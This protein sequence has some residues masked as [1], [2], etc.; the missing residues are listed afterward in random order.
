VEQ[1]AAEANPLPNVVPSPIPQELLD[2]VA[3]HNVTAI[4]AGN[5]DYAQINLPESA[6]NWQEHFNNEIERISS[7]GEQLD[8]R[9]TG[10]MQDILQTHAQANAEEVE[11]TPEVT[12]LVHPDMTL[13]HEAEL[14]TS[15]AMASV[16]L[17]E[18]AADIITEI[19][20]NHSQTETAALVDE[21][22]NN[23]QP[24]NLAE[25][26]ALP[27]TVTGLPFEAAYNRAVQENRLTP[28]L[29]ERY[30]SAV[31]TYNAFASLDKT[32]Q[33][34]RG[35]K[36]KTDT[37]QSVTEVVN[38]FGSPSA[39]RALASGLVNADNVNAGIGGQDET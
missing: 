5:S 31:K 39:Q 38:E 33:V 26:Q 6:D 35:I 11:P 15:V 20:S 19:G 25:V 27:Q 34:A 3:A 9:F 28:Q 22:T 24:V 12:R 23:P 36:A 32:E 17:G 10:E 30:A 8:T 29:A 21:L 2:A 18:D 14:N 1:V 7:T 4:N 37:L 16:T 13:A